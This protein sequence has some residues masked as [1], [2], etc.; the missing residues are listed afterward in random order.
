MKLIPIETVNR[1]I[2]IIK[3]DIESIKF[4]TYIKYGSRKLSKT[5]TGH[6]AQGCW[7]QWRCTAY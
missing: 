2:D 3:E 1:A 6:H 7:H 4:K 5:T